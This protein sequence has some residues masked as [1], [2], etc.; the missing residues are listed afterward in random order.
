MTVIIGA[1]CK[2]GIVVGSDSS[3]TFVAGSLPTI[4][5]PTKKTFVIGDD[6]IFAGTGQ[7]GLGQRIERSFTS[8]RQTLRR[9]NLRRRTIRSGE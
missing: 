3:A 9:M 6:I 2:D 7:C 5:Q 1:L 8:R 4:E